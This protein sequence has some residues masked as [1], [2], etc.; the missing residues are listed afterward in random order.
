MTDPGNSD[1]RSGAVR[2]TIVIV[3]ILVVA[4]ANA[5]GAVAQ[6]DEELAGDARG[7]SGWGAGPAEPEDPL[8]IM[9]FLGAGVG[10][11]LLRN[12]DFQQEFLAPAYLDL[13]AAVFFPGA[14]IRHGVGLG[15]TTSLTADQ[16]VDPF[17]QWALTPSYHFLVPL[18]RVVPELDHDWLHVQGRVG[19]PVVFSSVPGGALD[20]S[21]GGELAA[22][23][24]F[25][26]LAG[27]GLYLEV[28][29]ALYGGSDSTV[30]P[31]IGLD[32]GLMFDYEVLQ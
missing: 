11:R 17:M 14:E 15:V 4:L 21:V 13:G 29:A 10:I 23:L 3:T 12:L 16:N 9:G 1:Y 25:K 18:R 31:V 5:P 30:H 2:Q 24:H 28:S 7:E 8:R 32:A 22:A 26:F 19:V 6:V 27:L 20:I